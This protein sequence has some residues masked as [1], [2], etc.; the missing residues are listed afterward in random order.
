MPGQKKKK[1]FH[2]DVYLFD[3]KVQGNLN[4]DIEPSIAQNMHV[5][6]GRIQSIFTIA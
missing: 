1:L 3:L 4:G 5:V 6:I 2:F